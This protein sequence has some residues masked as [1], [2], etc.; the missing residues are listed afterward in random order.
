[1]LNRRRFLQTSSVAATAFA[2]PAVLRGREL[3]S[4]L[5]IAAIGCAGK[6]WSDTKEMSTHAQVQH[7][8]FCD[9]DLGR[10]EQ[11]K[12]LQPEAPIYQDYR[13]MLAS[14]GD[15]IDAVT[16]S[17][18][19]HMH[20]I[21]ALHAIRMGKHVYCQKPLTHTIWEARQLRE[22][23]A[24]Q[25]VITRLGNQIHSHTFYRT[26]VRAIQDGL[27][28]KVKR[29]HSWCAASGHGKC[30]FIDRPVHN[31]APPQTLN[32]DLWIGIAPWRPF[33]VLNCYHPF[34]WRDFQTFG[35]GALGDF[36]CHI[37]DPVFTALKID[38]DPLDVK[39]DH[40]GMNDEVWPAQTQVD[41]TFP[42]TELTVG[43]QLRITWYD[44]GRLPNVNDSHVPQTTAL[45]RSG[46]LFI[47]EQ[48]SLVLPHVG[49]L[50]LYPHEQYTQKI[51]PAEDL[52]HYHGWVD[53]CITGKQPSDGFDYGGR[54]TEAV[55]LG[56]I[57]VR[58]KGERIVWDAKN[59][60]VTNLEAANQWVT[61]E[62]RDGW[63]VTDV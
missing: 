4:K 48:G 28:G 55:L 29:V 11:V 15:T 25:G 62:Y 40:T 33:G 35:N 32:W 17:T 53:G 13:E 22:A 1:M 34:G 21:Q 56:N 38:G 43:D 14:H 26:A 12:Q 36:G 41:F 24:K 47:G 31:D 42:G 5:Q 46:S 3:N 61:R 37:L 58:H 20:A 50:R 18:P 6:G 23:A 7:V 10:V 52:N 2:A 30:G 16:V 57:A 51:E 49:E 60:R 8:A 54:L 27:I 9:V 45:P 63:E 59:L 19:D 44:G 39:A